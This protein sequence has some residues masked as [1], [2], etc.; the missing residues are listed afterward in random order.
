VTVSIRAVLFD[1]G[2]PLDSEEQ[3]ERLI[4]ANIR[5]ALA[6]EG[7]IVSDDR[8]A[9]ACK[10]VVDSFAPDAYRALLWGFS[11]HDRAAAERLA[12][13]D[14]S[15]GRFFELRPGIA[16]LLE[17]VKTRG[18]LLGL[19]ANQPAKAIDELD[20]QGI[21]HFFDHREVSGHHG[22]RKPDV[23]LFLHACR[24][25]DVVPEETVMVGDRIDNDIAPAK[26]LGMA[27]ILFR[28]G[29][30]AAQQ[31]RS[32]AEVPDAVVATVA[33]LEA[34]IDRVCASQGRE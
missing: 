16:E 15:A 20:R 2:G 33:Q 31:P 9:A 10:A 19:A 28:T 23:R 4:D 17:R 21:G 30:H 13:V 8:Y 6:A 12:A 11:S 7:I 5:A 26:A 22:F 3:S 29:R 27:A 32:L 24:D 14:V 1:V 18:L 34:A 25:L